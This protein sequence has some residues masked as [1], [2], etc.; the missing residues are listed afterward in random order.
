MIAILLVKVKSCVNSP[1]V[2][3]AQVS[4]ASPSAVIHFEEDAVCIKDGRGYFNQERKAVITL[5]DYEESFDEESAEKGIKIQRVDAK[6]E[7]LPASKE[8]ITIGEWVHK[9]KEHR[10]EVWF[11]ADGNYIWEMSYTNHVGKKL[12]KISTGSSVTPFCFTIDREAPF[13]TVIAESKEGKNLQWKNLLDAKQVLYS[14]E[15]IQVSG[16]FGDNTNPTNVKVFFHKEKLTI[17]KGQQILLDA[18]ELDEVRSWKEFQSLE[19][20]KDQ[21]CIVY[22]KVED[23]SGNY[24]YLNS[25]ILMVD[26]QMPVIEKMVTEVGESNDCINGIFHGDVFVGVSVA[27]PVTGGIYSGIQKVSYSVYNLGVETQCGVLY[28]NHPKENKYVESTSEWSGKFIV[29]SQK[30]NS[31]DVDV[32]ISVQDFSGNI[33]NEHMKLKIDISKPMIRVSYDN[34]D[35]KNECYFSKGRTG[36]IVIQERNFNPEGVVL[37]VDHSGGHI[38][39]LSE[40]KKKTGT[41]NLDDTKWIATIHFVEDGDYTFAIQ[42][43][44]LAG[45]SCKGIDYSSSVSPVQFTIDKTRPNIH[46]VFDNNEAKNQNYYN[47]ARILS[48]EIQEHNLDVEDINI[49]VTALSGEKSLD[50]PK[51]EG[52]SKEGDLYSAKMS[53]VEDGTYTFDIAVCDKAGNYAEDLE[54]Q[55]FH[56]DRTMPSVELSGVNTQSSNCGEVH[57]EVVCQDKNYLAEKT[58]VDLLYVNGTKADFLY[59]SKYIE[60]GIHYIYEEIPFERSRDGHYK[61]Q[62][63]MVDKAG[64]Y[65]EKEIPFSINRFGSVYT[66]GEGTRKI[67]NSYIYTLEDLIVKESNVD[68]LNSRKV[69]LFKNGETFLLQEEEDYLVESMMS[70][71]GKNE[72]VYTILKENFMENGFYKISILSEDAAGN[73]SSFETSG[74]PLELSFAVDTIKPIL[75]VHNLESGK[76]YKEESWNVT[77][78]VKDN[79]RLKKVDVYLDDEI[80]KSW[81]GNELIEIEEQADSFSFEIRGD[82]VFSHRVKIVCVDEAGNECLEEISNFYVTTNRWIYLWKNKVLLGGIGF[83]VLA[84]AR[85]LIIVCKK[86]SNPL[87]NFEN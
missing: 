3:E 70:Q 40:W 54:E 16:V 17:S 38:P 2:V 24:T 39:K 61:L 27:E 26:T 4:E 76:V 64:N 67:K 32:L 86:R 41:G 35:V 59:R 10:V 53:F 15:M 66:L 31:N 25:G 28:E 22:F 23:L 83:I 20:S 7:R 43:R 77:M 79:F 57:L 56:V 45:N 1:V 72:Y 6:G 19:I 8:E 85:I 55:I 9:G 65:I 51:M 48:I 30:N 78:S 68:V 33:K 73:T 36:T 87:S 14:N 12:E 58:E 60:N 46:I 62:V 47:K 5:M 52:W 71:N 18:N 63:K 74:E 13:G 50:L 84:G 81:S 11:R 21:S 44:D 75:T 82:A 80:Y 29:N 49:F 34:N 42:Y 69:I 37:Q